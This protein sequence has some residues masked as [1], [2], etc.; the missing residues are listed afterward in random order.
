[1]VEQRCNKIQRSTGHPQ[2]CSCFAE[3]NKTQKKLFPHHFEAARE[4]A[5]TVN[6]QI[7]AAIFSLV[8]PL[9]ILNSEGVVCGT[10]EV[11]KDVF[12]FDP[13]GMSRR[14]LLRKT[15]MRH[16]DGKAIKLSE[17]ACARALRGE[18]VKNFRFTFEDK[19]R[20]LRATIT[21]SSPVKVGG[22][23]VG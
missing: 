1:M 4:A 11:A 12:G 20:H 7:M 14:Q 15:K 22:T 23:V 16:A 6:A 17:M 21:S 2:T 9:I 13:V 10:N 19:A 3:E 8:D 5:S 18:T